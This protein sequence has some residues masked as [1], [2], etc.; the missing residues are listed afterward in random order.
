M[1]DHLVITG[2]TF[3]DE[4]VIVSYFDPA[5]A[6]NISHRETNEY[7]LASAYAEEFSLI[8]EA[9]EDIIDDIGTQEREPPETLPSA[10]ERLRSRVEASEEDRE[11]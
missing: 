4:T 6:T 9:I 1:A 5:K 7:I 11:A 3:M 8:K 10:A 2:I